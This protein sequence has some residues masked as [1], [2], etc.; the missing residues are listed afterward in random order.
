MSERSTDTGGRFAHGRVRSIAA[1]VMLAIGI[2]FSIAAF[3]VN[4]SATSPL[5]AKAQCR[6]NFAA[7]S[8]HLQVGQDLVLTWTAIGADKL[9]A[10]W[11]SG[12]IPFAGAVTTTMNRGGTFS[13][14]ITGTIA[15]QYCGGAGV[16]VNFS[17]DSPSQHVT[18]TPV[19]NPTP[20]HHNGG[21]GGNGNGGNGGTGNGGTATGNGGNGTT[22]GGGNGTSNGGENAAGN[23]NGG[24]GTSNGGNAT[25]NGGGNGVAAGNTNHGTGNYPAQSPTS[26]TGVAWLQQP[27]NLLAIG[28]LALLLSLALWKRENIRAPFVHQH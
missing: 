15:G 6:I 16:E 11:T 28:G 23:G 4:A 26:G 2:G 27:L 18:T 7:S 17:G 24:N 20:T 14:Q 25:T 9:S 1:A 12:Y 13:Y 21:N 19:S 8:L 3:A 5:R 22:N 10:S